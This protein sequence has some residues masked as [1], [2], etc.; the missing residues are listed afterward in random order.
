[1]LHEEC[2]CGKW[3]GCGHQLSS[4]AASI[5]DFRSVLNLDEKLY[6]KGFRENLLRNVN[7]PVS[8][9]NYECLHGGHLPVCQQE[10]IY[11]YSTHARIGD[12]PAVH[13]RSY[14]DLDS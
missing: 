9:G 7:L 2:P 13:M 3:M 5:Q 12:V 14:H 10:S 1:M 4:D 6:W 8:S 11:P